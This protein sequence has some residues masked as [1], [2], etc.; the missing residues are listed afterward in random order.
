MKKDDAARFVTIVLLILSV[1]S[2]TLAV[3]TIIA[4]IAVKAP[5]ALFRVVWCV[6]AAAV[7]YSLYVIVTLV[8]DTNEKINALWR[9]RE[10]P[11]SPESPRC[12]HPGCNKAVYSSSTGLCRE[13]F[14][15]AHPEE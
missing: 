12:R 3:V 10:A 2:L 15:E 9:S 14:L 11:P 7:F 4:A 6:I 1:L 5:G 8:S 13:H